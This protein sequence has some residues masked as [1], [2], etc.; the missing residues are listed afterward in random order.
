M[1]LVRSVRMAKTL[2]LV[3][4]SLAIAPWLPAATERRVT[5]MK[6]LRDAKNI[7]G[8]WGYEFNVEMRWGGYEAGR[9]NI[10]ATAFVVDGLRKGDCDEQI[11]STAIDFIESRLSRGDYIAYVEDSDA[12]I[13]NANLLGAVT[14]E[15]LVPDHPLV[16]RSLR[17]TLGAQGED[18]T[19]PYGEERRTAW[20]D[21]F[22][23]GYILEALLDL[24]EAHPEVADNL[25]RGIDV[26]LREGFS[27]T[28]PRYYLG[29]DDGP[30]DVHN[31]ATSL[32]VLAR[33]SPKRELAAEL[34]D[35]TLSSLGKLRRSDGT[36][37]TRGRG[38]PYCRWELAHVHRALAEVSA[39][40]KESI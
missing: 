12:L 20:V 32:S 33:L 11:S 4:G 14:L 22:H 19:W 13:H 29:R 24:E 38:E 3:A 16:R 21:S 18:G 36:F 1:L 10:V 25:E 23:T 26:W 28:G 8:G 34:I 9:S 37:S 27:M 6:D 7:D 40:D 5:L 2:G 31:I 17:T 15:R 30:L 39:L 35:T